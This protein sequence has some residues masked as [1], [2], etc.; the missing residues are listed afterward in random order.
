MSNSNNDEIVAYNRARW[1][2]L[3]NA[4]VMYSLPYLDL[5]PESARAV[6]D[7]YGHLPLS[8]VGL[9]VLC[10]AGGGGQHSAAFTL[11][12]ADVTV[13]DL[14]EVM[15]ERGR[16]TAAHYGHTIRT[17][18]GDMQT[19]LAQFAD[20]SFDVV[21][22][23]YSLNYVPDAASVFAQ[24]SRITAPMGMYHVA[25]HNP[26]AL[27]T[28]SDSWNGV[29][30]VVRELYVDGVEVAM[31]ETIWVFESGGEQKW[32]AS[33][34]FFRHTLGAVVNGLA[35]NGFALVG[36]HEEPTDKDATQPGGSWEH[37]TRV[38]PPFLSL[39]TRKHL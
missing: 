8:L 19:D 36:L 6:A 2:E 39:W 11:L 14:S 13:F 4:G 31:D 5:T 9:R 21:H 1:D 34:R 17:V 28:S 16:E 10:L 3:A 37:Y 33:P 7:P 35:H 30:Y 29:G 25:I 23:P 12:G 26:F 20:A 27:N 24:V 22:H 32:V 38:L 18:R 15:L